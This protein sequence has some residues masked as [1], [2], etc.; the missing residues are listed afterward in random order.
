[1]VHG[2][3][4]NGSCWCQDETVGP[5]GNCSNHKASILDQTTGCQAYLGPTKIG[6]LISAVRIR[7]WEAVKLMCVK[8]TL[9]TRKQIRPQQEA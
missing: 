6:H 9:L 4:G 2:E 8:V 1:M 7:A 5:I 3:G